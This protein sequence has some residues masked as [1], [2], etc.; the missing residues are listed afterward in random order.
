PHFISELL[1]IPNVAGMKLTTGQLLEISTIHLQAGDKLRL[2]SGAD[3]LLCQASL[4]GTV[5]A[6]G[7]FYNLWGKACKR[8][9]GAFQAGD[10]ALGKAFMLDFQRIILH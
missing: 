7:T 2:F 1:K 8:V 10:Y 5:G 9:L 3:E 4:C 6:I